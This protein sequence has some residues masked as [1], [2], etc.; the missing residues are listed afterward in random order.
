MGSLFSCT[1]QFPR[2]TKK[3]QARRGDM[4]AISCSQENTQVTQP[5]GVDSVTADHLSRD[6]EESAMKLEPQYSGGT[7][8]TASLHGDLG[9]VS[10]SQEG[11][12]IPRQI[13]R[14]PESTFNPSKIKKDILKARILENGFTGVFAPLPLQMGYRAAFNTSPVA[15]V[16][17]LFE[18]PSRRFESPNHRKDTP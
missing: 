6:L 17:E 4:V 18:F 8:Q 3:T 7:E 16:Q 14:W 11:L 10:C 15:H 5:L 9:T 1:S 2:V 12:P 13:Y